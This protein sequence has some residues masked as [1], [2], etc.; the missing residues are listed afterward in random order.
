MYWQE[1]VFLWRN[2]SNGGI[3][4][5]TKPFSQVVKDGFVVFSLTDKAY[6]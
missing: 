6:L 1:I 5:Q 3:I 2:Y 4:E